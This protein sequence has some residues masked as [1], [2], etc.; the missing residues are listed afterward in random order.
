MQLCAWIFILKLAFETPP[1][2]ILRIPHGYG[3]ETHLFLSFWAECIHCSRWEVGLFSPGWFRDIVRGRSALVLSPY[4]PT[5]GEICCIPWVWTSAMEDGELDHAVSFAETE[6]SVSWSKVQLEEGT[7]KERCKRRCWMTSYL[8]LN[9]QPWQT[10]ARLIPTRRQWI[11]FVKSRWFFKDN[12][13][14]QDMNRVLFFLYFYLFVNTATT[15]SIVVTLGDAFRRDIFLTM[16]YT[17]YF[18]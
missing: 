13:A 11:P 2:P 17:S 16:R 7:K 18:L 12:L 5:R 3:R 10:A 6:G 14:A 15:S 9:T 1:F 4:E 8:F